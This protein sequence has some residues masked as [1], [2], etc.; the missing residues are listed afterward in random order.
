[1]T[2]DNPNFPFENVSHMNE[3]RPAWAAR[4]RVDIGDFEIAVS[5]GMFPGGAYNVRMAVLGNVSIHG[6][7]FFPNADEAR[8]VALALYNALAT[9]LER[10]PKGLPS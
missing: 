5:Y 1:M 9:L 7:R 8:A 3:G 2:T 4:L 10:K 6:P